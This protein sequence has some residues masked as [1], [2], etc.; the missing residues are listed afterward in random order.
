M[1]ESKE[2]V[3]SSNDAP[4]TWNSS[5]KAEPEYEYYGDEFKERAIN[6]NAYLGALLRYSWLVILLTVVGT[7]LAVVYVAQKPDYF[8][9]SARVQVNRENNPAIDSAKAGSIVVNSADD[10]SYFST[11]FQ[12]LEGSGL[13]R[14]VV[15]TLDLEH[16]QTFVNP[17]KGQERTKWQNVLH[18]IGIGND[19]D[20]I[21]KPSENQIAINTES[22]SSSYKDS[23]EDVERLTPYVNLLKRGLDISPVK[24]KRVAWG[25][26]RLIDIEYTHNDPHIASLVANAIADIYVLNNLEQKIQTNA[27]AGDFLQKRVAELQSQIRSGEETLINYSKS[28]QLLSLD[29]KQDVV[30][31]RLT[32]LNSRLMEAE[33]E[34]NIAEAAYR[35]S[36]R[37]GAVASLTEGTDAQ[38]SQLE[39]KLNDLRQQRLQLLSEYKENSPEVLDIDR[40]IASVKNDVNDRKAHA[41]R[42]LTTN[43]ETKY[44]QALGR[45]EDLRGQF[46]EQRHAVLSQNE[47]AI[48]YKIVQQEI[49]T[50]KSLLQG[51]LQRSKENDVILNDTPNNISVV[52]R[53][54]TPR[55]PS[56]P[57]RSGSVMIAF[58]MSFVTGIGL[59]LLIKFF[60]D[61]VN[62]VEDVETSLRLPV[63]ASIPSVLRSSNYKKL[64]LFKRQREVNNSDRALTLV[65]S[66]AATPH[67]LESYLHLRTSFLLATAGGPPKKLLV[68]SSQPSEGKT[69]TAI[70]LATVLSQVG[71]KVLLIDCDLRR[72]SLHQIFNLGNGNGL[73]TLLAAKDLSELDIFKAIQK[74]EKSGLFILTTG[75]NPPNPAN[76]FGSEQMRRLMAI[77]ESAFNHIII[78]SPPIVLF[79]DSAIL[80]SL[81]DG[82][83]LVVRK[84]QASRELMMRGRKILR[85][86]GARIFGVVFNDISTHANSYYSNGYYKASESPDEGD[87]SSLLG[88]TGS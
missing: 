69:T 46:E 33:N 87:G 54:L 8:E 88:L 10:P 83:L 49:E 60:D 47:A 29:E 15:K 56:G 63:V 4:A 17:Q 59:V 18:F 64:F 1:S 30:V 73:S 19:G 36:L 26:T 81:V 45:E 12:I 80:S 3:Y 24:E 53:A 76:L 66:P 72:P 67:F 75:P 39:S 71:T 51:L 16:N 31:Q 86:V 27:T 77:L 52:D 79:T 14:R 78:D 32:N 84:G 42:M 2:L 38:S 20:R 28:H 65:S 22:F 13:L 40:Q 34:R 43:L 48:N 55:S 11:Q 25:E 7:L 61:T 50:N 70:N 9:A 6:F 58:M 57:K 23:Q 85:D 21:Q 41:D 35:A 5:Q 37:P 44:R 82:T 62:D 68:T 74:D